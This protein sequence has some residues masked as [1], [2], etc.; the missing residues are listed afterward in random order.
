MIAFNEA[1]DAFDPQGGASFLSFAEIVIKRR[2][3]DFFRRQA[4]RADEI[5]LSSFEN[6]ENENSMIEKIESK[7]A[8]AVLQIQ[9]EAEERREEVF[10]LDQLLNHYGIRFSE[11]VK[12]S[13]KHQD[14]RDRALKVARILVNDPEL[15]AHL[16]TKKSLP[17]KQL[18]G[19]VEVSR[20]TLERQRKYIIALTLVLIGDFHHLQEYLNRSV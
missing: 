1:I 17:L 9:E 12:I 2:M 13:P 3:V 4:R 10:R 5:P 8:H 14:A 18:E 20:K 19:R 16:T 11:L 7:E 15:L 6:D